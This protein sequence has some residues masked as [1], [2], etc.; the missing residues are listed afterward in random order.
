M[1]RAD[2]RLLI[3]QPDEGE[4]APLGFEIVLNW[5]EE[6]KQRVPVGR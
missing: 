1:W 3:V 2:G 6:L 4:S 5:F